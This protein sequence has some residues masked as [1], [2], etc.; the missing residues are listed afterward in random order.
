MI[1]LQKLKDDELLGHIQNISASERKIYA[2]IIEA[3]EEIERRKLY[4][5][6]G[7]SSLFSFCTEFLKYSEGAAQR[8]IASMRLVKILP[9]AEKSIVKT[10]IE[11]GSINLTHLSKVSQ[12]LRTMPK[13]LKAPEKMK[14]IESLENTTKDECERKLIEAGAKPVFKREDLRPINSEEYRLSINLDTESLQALQEYIA[15]T[16]HQNPWASKEKAVCM[17][18]QSAL[19]LEKKKRTGE[20]TSKAP[21]KSSSR[22]KLKEHNDSSKDFTAAVAAKPR[23]YICAKTKRKVWSRD[24]GVCQ[25]VDP[26]T[27]RSCQSKHALQLDH[28]HEFAKGGGNE[29]INLRLLCAAHNRHR[30]S[31]I[32]RPKAH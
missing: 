11:A 4:L 5:A 21:E 31:V 29:A 8:R 7:Y 20:I 30:R 10:K 16:A 13:T 23:R 1:R 18:I 28:I 17:A 24:K 22:A 12:A 2:D 26:K 3:L 14:L 32:R 19:E 6:R 27:G 15:L 25:Y 9:P